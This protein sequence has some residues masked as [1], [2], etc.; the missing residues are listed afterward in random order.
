MGMTGGGES[1][2]ED[3]SGSAIVEAMEGNLVAYVMYCSC[4]PGAQVHQ[5]PDHITA[6]TG[7]L[8]PSLNGVMRTRLR[9]DNAYERIAEIL[10]PFKAHQVP[11]LWWIFPG[12]QP[13]NLARHLTAHG[14]TYYQDGPGMVCG[15]EFLPATL[16]LPDGCTIEA[17]ESRET[18]D[19]WIK[20]SAL[21]FAGTSQ[22]IDPDYVAFERCLGWESEQPYRRFLAR[23]HGEPVAT[24]ALFLGAGVAG[25]Y[26]VGTLP[27]ARRLGIG[28]AISLAPLLKAR[29]EG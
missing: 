13:I 5:G 15:L 21:I 11:M 17:V 28:T 24:S 8:Q 19:E 27:T 22:E 1:Q 12:T 9:E 23:L 10:E 29:D 18:L 14:L 26:S 20:T 16:S 7:I 4:I 3:F 6:L 25:L 2:S